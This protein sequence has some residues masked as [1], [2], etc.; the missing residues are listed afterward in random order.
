MPIFDLASNSSK[1]FSDLSTKE[2]RQVSTVRSEEFTQLS[3]MFSELSPTDLM[4]LFVQ[5]MVN[6]IGCS[7]EAAV[8]SLLQLTDSDPSVSTFRANQNSGGRSPRPT[9]ESGSDS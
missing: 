8:S 3:A 4:R 2:R 1:R 9:P 5:W 6:L 7:E